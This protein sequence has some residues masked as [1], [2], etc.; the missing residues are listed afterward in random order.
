[1]KRV[2]VMALFF[3]FL[4]LWGVR[5]G[6]AAP[7]VLAA[8]P[9]GEPY[10]LN[11]TEG[12]CGADFSAICLQPA[13]KAPASGTLYQVFAEDKGAIRLSG[14]TNEGLVI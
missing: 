7:Q 11:C 4:T 1:M 6:I 12:I 9:V 13:R 5:S 2:L 3:L 10:V 8:V 14:I